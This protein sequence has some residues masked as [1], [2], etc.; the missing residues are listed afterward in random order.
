[1]L[2]PKEKVELHILMES[3]EIPEQRSEDKF[4]LMRNLGIKNKNNTNFKRAMELIKRM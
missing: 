4:W 3:M 2:S 1:M